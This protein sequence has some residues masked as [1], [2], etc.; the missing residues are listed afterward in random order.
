MKF[1]ELKLSGV[2]LFEKDGQK[3]AEI[4]Q[5]GID[6]IYKI[7][8]TKFS[9]KAKAV[10]M[11]LDGT[12][13]KSEEFWIYLIEK[14]VQKIIGNTS[15]NF[16][17][18]DIPFVSGYSTLQHLKYCIDKYELKIDVSDANKI[19]HAIAE[20][21]LKEI[22]KGGGNINAFK[23]RD[24]LKDFL[25]QLKSDGIKIGLVS[26]GLEY[27]AIPEIVSAFR[28]LKMGNPLDFY[29]AVMLGGK[30]KIKGQY[31]TMGETCAKPHPYIYYETGESLCREREK[32]ITIEDSSAGVISSIVA[33]Y[34][35][36]GFRDGNIVSS[37]ADSLCHK[38]VNDFSEIYETIAKS[39]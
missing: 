26:S 13:V 37:H 39:F 7:P 24:G 20:T 35:V 8:T 17:D 5:T 32:V 6:A 36:I 9:P 27:K 15:F 10:L 28:V 34:E 2:K 12:T 22:L 1:D 18:E 33:G 19:Y 38:C 21:E 4:N 23:P 14:T 29:D 11:D 31:G 25:T 3:Y 16:S 30:R